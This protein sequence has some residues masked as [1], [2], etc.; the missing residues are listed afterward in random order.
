M[1]TA[2]PK[3]NKRRK[4]SLKTDECRFR[5]PEPLPAPYPSRMAHRPTHFSGCPQP[6]GQPEKRLHC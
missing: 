3:A 4:G 1:N 2:C 6:V 5:L